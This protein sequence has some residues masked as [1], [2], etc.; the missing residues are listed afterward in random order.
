MYTP[1]QTSDLIEN[2]MC[3]VEIF[4]ATIKKNIAMMAKQFQMSSKK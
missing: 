1:N 4:L 2:L 3:T